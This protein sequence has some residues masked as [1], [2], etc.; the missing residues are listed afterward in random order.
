MV[1][2]LC[3]IYIMCTVLSFIIKKRYTYFLTIF[4]Y[5][6]YLVYHVYHV[7][8]FFIRTKKIEKKRY[9]TTVLIQIVEKPLIKSTAYH[10]IQLKKSFSLPDSDKPPLLSERSERK[11]GELTEENYDRGYDDGRAEG[12]QE[13][14]SE[15][16]AKWRAKGMTDEEINALLN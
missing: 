9:T 10:N 12:K 6:L 8:R 1:Y 4:L 5:F 15:S 7:Y 13:R 2:I 14:D 3:T 16:I 11:W